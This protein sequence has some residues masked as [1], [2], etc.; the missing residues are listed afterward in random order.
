MTCGGDAS[1]PEKVWKVEFSPGAMG[2]AYFDGAVWLGVTS[3]GGHRKERLL[4]RDHLVDL[5]DEAT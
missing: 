3:D 5:D 2:A 4:E 1:G